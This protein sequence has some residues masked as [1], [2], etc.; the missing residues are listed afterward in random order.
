[1]GL[2][3]DTLKGKGNKADA[4]V[5][6]VLAKYDWPVLSVRKSH[7]ATIITFAKPITYARRIRGAWENV[8][9]IQRYKVAVAPYQVATA[10][11]TELV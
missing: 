10:D 4:A 2:A 8:E 11:Y 7:D 3:H 5:A 6:S 9:K 1:M